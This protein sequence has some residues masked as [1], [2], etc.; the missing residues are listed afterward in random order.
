MVNINRPAAGLS[1]AEAVAIEIAIRVAVPSD[2][3]IFFTA[4]SYWVAI[5]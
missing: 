4:P 3:Y 2:K 5:P 1:F